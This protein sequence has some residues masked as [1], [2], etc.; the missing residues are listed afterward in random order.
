MSEIIGYVDPGTAAT[1][2]QLAL[3][4]VVGISALIKLKWHQ[5]KRI[6]SRTEAAGEASV[7]EKTDATSE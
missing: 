3:A 5:I 2:M 1:L 7:R 6:F 4:G